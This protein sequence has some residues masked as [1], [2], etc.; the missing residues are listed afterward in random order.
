[1]NK[2]LSFTFLVFLASISIILAQNQ[3]DIILRKKILN[4]TDIQSN[5]LNSKEYTNSSVIYYD[6]MKINDSGFHLV[7]ELLEEWL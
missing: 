2:L 6:F 3:R 4:K 1:M 5:N 7:E